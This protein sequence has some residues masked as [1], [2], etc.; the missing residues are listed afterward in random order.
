MSLWGFSDSTFIILPI[1]VIAMVILCKNYEE[2][3]EEGIMIC[4]VRK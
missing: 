2:E 3:E 4:L 1:L